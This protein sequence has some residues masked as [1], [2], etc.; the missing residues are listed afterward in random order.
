MKSLHL[1]D[2]AELVEKDTPQPKPRKG[3]VLVRVYGAGITPSEVR[4]F[5]YNLRYPVQSR[6]YRR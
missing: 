4:E 1:T 6:G 3:E 5:A 2:D